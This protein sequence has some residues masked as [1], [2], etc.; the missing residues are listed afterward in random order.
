[1]KAYEPLVEEIADRRARSFLTGARPPDRARCSCAS[2]CARS[3][4]RCSA[5]PGARCH[6]LEALLPPW[7]AQAQSLARL[8]HL[9][10][11]LG[12]GAR[13][14]ASYGC[15]PASTRSSTSSS[16]TRAAT[17]RSTIARRARAVVRAAAH[18]RPADDRPRDPRPARDDDDRRPRDDVAHAGLGG[19]A[20]SPPPRG[21][22]PPRR[23]G[24]RRRAAPTAPPRSARCSASARWWPSPAGSPEALR[25]RRPH[26]LP[27]RCADRS[28]GVAYPLRSA[29]CSPKPGR[30]R[31]ERFLDGA[32]TPSLY[33]F[34]GGCWRCLGAT[35]AHMEMDV[36][37]RVAV[38]AHGAAADGRAGRARELQGRRHQ[39]RA[40]RDGTGAPDHQIG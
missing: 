35:F 31:P 4:A 16:R 25:A 2:P 9:Q 34:G 5:R 13:G 36:V 33:P 17:R 15:A 19:R 11:D 21:A 8:P 24:R 20:A 22:P 12:P 7:T 3:C 37:L 23:R 30:F 38:G 26:V 10:R 40:R 27:A 18:E 32:R 39:P 14:G 28:V 6:E 1:M 29:R